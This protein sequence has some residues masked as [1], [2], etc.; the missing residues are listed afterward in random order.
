M[1]RSDVA[2]SDSK[3]SSSTDSS[4]PARREYS[5]TMRSE[6]LSASSPATNAC[7]AMAPALIIGLRGRPVDGSNEISLKASP[8]G[9]TSI[10]SSTP[11]SPWSWIANA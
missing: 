2:S 9:S 3:T 4:R 11:A 1:L 8:D 6:R 7:A 10:R 5:S